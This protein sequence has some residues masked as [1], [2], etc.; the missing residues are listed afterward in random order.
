MP[1]PCRTA[2]RGRVL[3]RPIASYVSQ[4]PA[5]EDI[6]AFLTRQRAEMVD[7]FRTVPES[8]GAHR[9]APGSGA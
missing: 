9:Y 1:Y 3:G 8:R 7:R 5:G 6:V 2:G 4:V